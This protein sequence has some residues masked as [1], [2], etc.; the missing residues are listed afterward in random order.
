LTATYND[1]SNATQDSVLDG[2]ITLTFNPSSDSELKVC[3]TATIP[4]P[5]QP[6]IIVYPQGYYQGFNYGYVNGYSDSQNGRPYDDRVIFA[7]SLGT[8]AGTGLNQEFGTGTWLAP[9]TGTYGPGTGSGSGTAPWSDGEEGFYRGYI[10]GYLS[11]WTSA[12]I[13][14]G[15]GSGTGTYFL[16]GTSFPPEVFSLWQWDA[17]TSTWAELETNCITPVYPDRNGWY[18]GEI[19]TSDCTA[20]GT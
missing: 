4:T 11:G 5:P 14:N 19:F 1:G 20:T 3:V 10:E 6:P 7:G 17:A 12:A 16:P 9:G 13:T 15:T 18:D 2:E 8:G